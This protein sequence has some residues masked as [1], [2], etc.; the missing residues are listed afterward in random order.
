[1]QKTTRFKL[2]GLLAISVGLSV[3]Q[4]A[5]TFATPS[6]PPNTTITFNDTM[7][8]LSVSVTGDATGPA[9]AN[10]S[11]VGETCTIDVGDPSTASGSNIG[12]LD[13]PLNILEPGSSI[14]SDLLDAGHQL[15]P[16]LISGYHLTF[17]SDT[18]EL[19]GLGTYT[20]G[21]GS[22]MTETGGI[23][24]A[25]TITWSSST[26]ATVATATIRFQ[27]DIES[28]STGVPEPMSLAMFG[29]GLIGLGAMRR[30][31]SKSRV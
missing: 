9:T 12:G 26:G 5:T 29:A 22:V 11:C 18:N 27:S 30:R 31:R 4:P 14:I 8:T 1:M 19:L 10:M 15:I 23:Q 3:F 25:F 16:G 7:D 17:Q 6:I 21:P 28:T 20:G 13:L 2:L 24:D